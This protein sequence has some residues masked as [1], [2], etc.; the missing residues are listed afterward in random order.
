MNKLLT[1][2][3]LVLLA[4]SLA[5]A[6]VV[7]LPDGLPQDPEEIVETVDAEYV[8]SF[9][10]PAG[11]EFKKAILMVEN[12]CKL[13]NQFKG[14]RAFLELEAGF[15]PELYTR[16]VS[17]KPRIKF[18][19]LEE[20]Y[21]QA[22]VDPAQYTT[23]QMIEVLN[24]LAKD[25]NYYDPKGIVSEV[26]IA[27]ETTTEEVIDLLERF[28]IQRGLTYDPSK[29][30]T[31]QED[32]NDAPNNRPFDHDEELRKVD[33]KHS[34]AEPPKDFDY[35]KVV[36]ERDRIMQETSE[37]KQKK[38]LEKQ[39]ALKKAAAK[40]STGEEEEKPKKDEL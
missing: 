29:K 32:G 25:P 13:R 10:K 12:N 7:P 9:E 40:A 15:Y 34:V 22:T 18:Y 30:P 21:I 35:E 37:M 11:V 8:T 2:A 1:T 23:E 20:D 39:E 3:L 16:L 27:R 14:T 5:L 4:I 33:P 36:D 19:E 24:N 6:Q 31:L 28:G 17:G 26:F 38:Y